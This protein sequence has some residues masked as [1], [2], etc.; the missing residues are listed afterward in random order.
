MKKVVITGPRQAE[1]VE[2][3][4]PLPKH[5]WVV[6]KV[7]IAPMCTE[8]KSWVAG[9]PA[10]NLGHEAVG[11][12]TAV[13]QP[14]RVKVG[15][16]VVVQPLYACGT[17]D[18]CIAGDYIHCQDTISFS[19]F[20]GSEEGCATYMQYLLKPDWQ[21]SRIPDDVPYENAALACCALGPS[22]GAFERMAVS[23]F[24]TVLITGLGPVGLGA[25]LN[26]AFRGAR[27][28]AV[29]SIAYRQK[30][31]KELG[32]EAVLDPNDGAIG[33]HI[34]D[35]TEGKGVDKA[36]DCSG[37]VK[38]ER[39]CIDATH[40]RGQV[41]FIGECSD[42][43][44]IRASDDLIRKGLTLHGSWQYNLNS[45]PEIMKVIRRSPMI[46]Q[47]VS[48]VFPMSHIQEALETSASHESAKILLRPWE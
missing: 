45:F 44:P 43:L 33:Q 27:V 14:C 3:P 5:N 29:D 32:A 40:R 15:D 30:K 48:H 18:L 9:H 46:G 2:V 34:L 28:I 47:L 11:E 7:H 25:T 42:E 20:I 24:D 37:T 36:L 26:A 22:F 23:A 4:D 12:V 17:C 16:R 38:A 35:L 10:R 1:I 21:L 8:Y 6:V 31:A 13:A 19:E 41:A 39:L